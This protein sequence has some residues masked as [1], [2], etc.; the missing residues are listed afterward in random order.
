[1]AKTPKFAKD[2]AL[3]VQSEK[4][5]VHY[6]IT[7]NGD[8]LTNGAGEIQFNLGSASIVKTNNYLVDVDDLL[9]AVDDIPNTRTR[10][11]F[12]ED[13]IVNVHGSFR[14]ATLALG[15]EVLVGGNFALG[16]TAPRAGTDPGAT[17]GSVFVPAGSYITLSSGFYGSNAG[18][19]VS[20]PNPVTLTMEIR[21]L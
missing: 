4:S 21:R 1:M 6:K 16:A 2:A 9:T 11:V 19:V 20:S 13:C 12:S 10:F 7:Q 18:S 15:V 14:C 17:S 3:V 5:P 8:A